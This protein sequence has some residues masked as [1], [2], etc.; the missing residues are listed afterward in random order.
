MNH[1][2]VTNKK[3]N[4]PKRDHKGVVDVLIIL[5]SIVLCGDFY[6]MAYSANND[7]ITVQP[8]NEETIILPIKQG[9]DIIYMNGEKGY[10]QDDNIIFI[11]ENEKE[12][13][14]ILF[15]H[16]KGILDEFNY[17][18]NVMEANFEENV[19]NLLTVRS[20]KVTLDEEMYSVNIENDKIVKNN[21]K[22]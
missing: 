2:F 12:G 20:Q 1:K 14:V 6:M 18:G 16:E 7:Y 10:L 3:L 8:I 11:Q 17:Y 19:L 15:H 22:R 21:E 5:I 9:Y 4:K 13:E